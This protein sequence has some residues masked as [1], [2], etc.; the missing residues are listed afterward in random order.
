MPPLG[1][2][3]QT[4]ET[5]GAMVRAFNKRQQNLRHVNEGH[6]DV[7]RALQVGERVHKRYDTSTANPLVKGKLGSRPFPYGSER[8][9]QDVNYESLANDVLRHLAKAYGGQVSRARVTRTAPGEDAYANQGVRGVYVSP[10]TPFAAF[11]GIKQARDRAL[12]T[13]VHEYAHTRQRPSLLSKVLAEGGADLFMRAVAP[14][15]YDQLGIGVTAGASSPQYA[16]YA[17]SVRKR[18]GLRYVLNQQFR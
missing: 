10:D 11:S 2:R 15:L 6:S 9:V 3:T 16:K 13:P 8:Q 5:R 7:K 14:S 4:K 12:T 18:G 17:R 1:P